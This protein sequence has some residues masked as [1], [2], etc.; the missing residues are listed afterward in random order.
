VRQKRHASG[1]LRPYFLH[2]RVP[3]Q[4]FGLSMLWRHPEALSIGAALPAPPSNYRQDGC[5]APLLP[6][7]KLRQFEAQRVGRDRADGGL[8]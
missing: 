3:T 2:F 6:G 1:Q 7:S 5:N 4:S 8:G